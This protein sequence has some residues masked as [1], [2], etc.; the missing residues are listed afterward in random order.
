MARDAYGRRQRVELRQADVRRASLCRV[1]F[2]AKNVARGRADS[3]RKIGNPS[4]ERG[5]TRPR[6]GRSVDVQRSPQ[7]VRVCER[8]GLGPR[9]S[10]FRLRNA[11]VRPEVSGLTS[12]GPTQLASERISPADTSTRGAALQSGRRRTG[13]RGARGPPGGPRTRPQTGTAA[14]RCDPARAALPSSSSS[15]CMPKLYGHG[16]KVIC[17]CGRLA[18]LV[19]REAKRTSLPVPSSSSFTSHP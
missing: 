9:T 1:S 18:V 10:G 5:E 11:L 7:M 15:P 17:S 8:I 2:H 4:S 19:S 13:A 12:E 14:R 6:R 3:Y 16:T